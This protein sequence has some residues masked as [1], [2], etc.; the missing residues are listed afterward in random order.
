ML[1]SSGLIG[2]QSVHCLRIREKR[3]EEEAGSRV[4]DALRAQHEKDWE[5]PV[6]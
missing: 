1:R 2:K 3:L 6:G 4:P 5:T